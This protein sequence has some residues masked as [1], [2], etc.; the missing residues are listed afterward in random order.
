[1][2]GTSMKFDDPILI[3]IIIPVL[4]EEACLGPMLQHLKK[5][6]HDFN[7]LEILVVDGGSTDNSVSV[8]KMHGARVVSS[9]K[10]RARQMN[11]GAKHARGNTLYFLHADTFPPT[12][13]D[14]ALIEALQQGYDAGCFRLKFNDPSRFLAFFAWF[15]QFN[16]AICRGGDQSLFIHKAFF[17]ELGGFNEAYRIYEDNEFISR[18]YR[19]GKF[20]ILPMHVKTSARKYADN[21]MVNLQYH[22]AVVHLKQ[23]MGAPPEKLYD[24]YS[25]NIQSDL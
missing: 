7:R 10:G 18:I 22:F 11:L 17:E 24:Y 20:R 6:A 25:R 16:F 2:I 21:G 3:S 23:Y 9:E 15:S 14:V 13:F 4:N 19:K 1:M 8:A 5:E 12:H